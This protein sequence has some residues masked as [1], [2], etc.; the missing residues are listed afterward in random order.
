MH[1]VFSLFAR[2]SLNIRKASCVGRHDDRLVLELG[3]LDAEELHEVLDKAGVHEQERADY[4]RGKE[5]IYP[6]A[7]KLAF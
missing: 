5:I 7:L 1:S 3:V 4:R 2:H 6:H